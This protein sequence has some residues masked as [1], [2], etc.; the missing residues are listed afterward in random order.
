MVNVKGKVYKVFWEMDVYLAFQKLDDRDHTF[1]V[2]D[3]KDNIWYLHRT[4]N[5]KA[6]IQTHIIL[7]EQTN[8][9]R[10]KAIL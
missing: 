5:N 9:M 1:S 7:D 4:Y 6:W 10:K 8:V 3:P 2:W